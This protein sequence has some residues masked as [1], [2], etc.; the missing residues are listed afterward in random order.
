MEQMFDIVA[1]IECYK[2]F[3]PWCQDSSVFSRR[4]GHCKAMISVGFSPI[5]EKYTSSVTLVK[6]HMVHVS[7]ICDPSWL[8]LRIFIYSN[9]FQYRQ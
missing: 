1:G 8:S 2:D 4:P 9:C 6:P 5:L 3:V 7:C